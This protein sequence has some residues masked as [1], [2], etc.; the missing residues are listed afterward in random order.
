MNTATP[1]QNSGPRGHRQ[2]LS[3][4]ESIVLALDDSAVSKSA[5]PVA[6]KL[7]QLYGATLH[8]AYVG[9]HVLG[10]KDTPAHLGFSAEEMR[11]AVFD[12]VKGDAIE[13]TVRLIMELP[14][15]LAVMC[16]QIGAQAEENRFGSITES[17]IASKPERAVLLT[18]ESDNKLWNLD[19]ILLAHDGTP[20][21]H[22]SSSLAAELAQLAGSEV[23]A[24]H[25]AARG[26]KPSTEAG[27]FPAPQ[28]MD[29]PQ[30]EWP[31]WSE[32]FMNRLIASGM[33]HSSVDFELLVTG[34][35]PGSEI[36][37]VARKRNVGLVI[38][39][40][41]AHW[42]RENCATRVVIRSSGCPVLLVQSATGRE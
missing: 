35:R 20:T 19:R 8:I 36:A 30:H 7:E 21:C 23:V 16:T 1:E 6:R 12:Q 3:S 27:S 37:Q 11:G 32:E 5:I 14:N 33:P 2:N 9:G 24:L 40:W 39:A 41:H 42:D 13:S 28:Y 25:V 29:Q 18:P 34:G 22:V 31:S 4:V 17:I 26:T 10:V 38:M 15:A